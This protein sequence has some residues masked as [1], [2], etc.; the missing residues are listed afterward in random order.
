MVDSG[1]YTRNLKQKYMPIE[2]RELIIKSTVVPEGGAGG[3]AAAGG[4]GAG[5]AGNN[6]TSP[7]EELIKTCVDKVLEIIKDKHGR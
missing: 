7:N 6:D 4:G 2:V 3:G 1:W 5:R